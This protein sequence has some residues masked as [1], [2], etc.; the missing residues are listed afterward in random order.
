MRRPVASDGKIP[1]PAGREIARAALF[2]LVASYWFFGANLFAHQAVAPMD[3]LS[4]MPGYSEG[5]ASLPLINQEKSDILDSLLP[6][7]RYAKAQLR[8]GHLPL[9]DPLPGG[10]DPLLTA[11]GAA[12]ITPRF[13][14]YLI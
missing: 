8:S 9:W 2:F 5:A 4:T 12:L 14:C 13:L 1:A 10:G 3:L 7:W 6:S 11:L